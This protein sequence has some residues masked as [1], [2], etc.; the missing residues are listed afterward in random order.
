MAVAAAA[1]AVLAAPRPAAADAYEAS[2]HLE[3]MAGVARLSDPLAPDQTAVAPVGGA[4]AR[5]TWATRDWL[6]WEVEAYGL[7]SGK[8]NARGVMAA[9]G[10]SHDFARGA[11]AVGADAGATLRL[12]VRFIPTVS[13]AIGPQLRLYPSAPFTAGGAGGPAVGRTT[14]VTTFDVAARA[15]LGFDYRLGAH[16]VVGVRASA[17]RALGIGDGAWTAFEGTA[18][19]SYYWYPRWWTF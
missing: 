2:I 12:G 11:T 16:W 7:A 19:L 6:A 1:V 5:F 18:F 8:V 17:R 3:A 10:R 9:D 13:V 15:S 14:G 4:G